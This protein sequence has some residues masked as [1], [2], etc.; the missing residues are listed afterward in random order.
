[1]DIQNSIMDIHN[2]I[3]GKYGLTIMDI[4]ILFKKDGSSFNAI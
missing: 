3:M 2:C 4:C 1:M